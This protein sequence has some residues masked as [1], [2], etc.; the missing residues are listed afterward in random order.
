MPKARMEAGKELLNQPETNSSAHTLLRFP[1]LPHLHHPFSTEEEAKHI[2][3]FFLNN[4]PF[5]GSMEV[6]RHLY[7]MHKCHIPFTWTLIKHITQL[8][9]CV[10]WMLPHENQ[11]GK[12]EHFFSHSSSPSPSLPE[13]KPA[14]PNAR[15]EQ[16]LDNDSPAHR[17]TITE[18]SGH[19]L[20]IFFSYI[21]KP[22]PAS[23]SKKRRVCG[24]T[25]TED[26][27]AEDHVWAVLCQILAELEERSV[28]SDVSQSTCVNSDQSTSASITLQ[29]KLPPS[30]VTD[31]LS[32][33]STRTD[34]HLSHSA[35]P[36]TNSDE[37]TTIVS[38][39]QSL[40]A[41]P[42]IKSD[43]SDAFT[44]DP[45]PILFL[46]L[47]KTIPQSITLS[48]DVGSQTFGIEAL[49]ILVRLFRTIDFC[50]F[51]HNHLH[52]LQH[53]FREGTLASQLAFVLTITLWVDN[54]QSCQSQFPR[55]LHSFDWEGFLHLDLND[56]TVLQ[57][58]IPNPLFSFTM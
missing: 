13:N 50:S 53:S 14:L 43:D 55:V 10:H 39:L 48:N 17:R 36:E 32:I 34:Q 8:L 1:S 45:D 19:A 24:G 29:T 9:A 26:T 54:T 16:S 3:G 47:P 4:G 2:K 49:R 6:L 25:I 20:H 44:N 28:Q 42:P 33:E 57:I 37:S 58:R 12:D 7:T 11:D 18:A 27:L 5:G 41:A 35:S 38:L 56:S 31:P 46:R 23:S 21:R 51:L 30:E 40:I 52:T 22:R 15:H